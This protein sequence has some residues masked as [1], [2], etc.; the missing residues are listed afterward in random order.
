MNTISELN[1]TELIDRFYRRKALIIAVF[2][3]ISS[4]ATYLAIVVPNVYRSSTL[5]A[6]TPQKVPSTF[7]TSTVTLDLNDRMQAIVQEIL[8]RPQLEAIINE[9]RLSSPEISGAT[10]DDRIESLRKKINV[11]SR[12]NNVFELSFDSRNAET[13]KQVTSRWPRCS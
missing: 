4:L 2:L 5:I 13:A 3:V 7:V 10:L 6:V 9:F 12:R 1:L 11:E 8:S